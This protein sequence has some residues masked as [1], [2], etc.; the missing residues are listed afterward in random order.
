MKTTALI[1]VAFLAACGGGGNEDQPISVEQR[2]CSEPLTGI[3]N[4]ACEVTVDEG[5]TVTARVSADFSATNTTNA[6]A[7]YRRV[8]LVRFG[9]DG[10]AMRDYTGTLQPGQSVTLRA[11]TEVTAPTANAGGLPA[12]VGLSSAEPLADLPVTVSN[13]IVSVTQR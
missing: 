5:T 3:I 11:L 2:L 6:P 8:L 13:I 10:Y 1:L 7:T 9:G 12:F 4:S